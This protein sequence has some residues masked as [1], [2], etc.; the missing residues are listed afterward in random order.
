MDHKP[1][2]EQNDLITR[3]LKLSPFRIAALY[4][5]AGWLWIAFSDAALGML[6]HD[7]D[8]MT[9]IAMVKG[10]AYVAVTAAILYVLILRFE[11]TSLESE[12]GYRALLEQAVDGIVITDQDANCLTVNAS[13]CAMLGYTET[14]FLRLNFRDLILPEDLAVTPLRSNEMLSGRTVL[15]DRMLR[16][17]DG[18]ILLAEISGKML[19]DGRLLAMVRDMSERKRA[20][21]ALEDSERRFRT[22]AQASFEG[23]ALTEQGVIVDVNDQLADMLGYD[24]SE[25]IGKPVMDIVA[26]ESRQ[27]VAEAMRSGR[28]ETYEHLALRKNGSVFPVEVRARSAQIGGRKVRV[29]AVRDV[30]ARKHLEE[31]LLQSQK[32]EAVGLLAGGVAHDFNNIL[33]AII[34]YGSVAKMRLPAGDPIVSYLDNILAS[35]ERAANLT[36]SLLAFS[37][38]QVIR[39]RP[40]YANGI[41]TKVGKLLA[42]LIGEDV[43]LNLELAG[44]DMTILADVGQIEQVLMNLATNGRDAMPSGGIL[45]IT[46]ERIKLDQDFVALS[47]FGVPGEYAMITVADTGMGMDE[48]TRER[49]FEPFFTTKKMGKGTGLGLS[50][51]YGIIKQHEGHITVDSEPGM[52]TLFTIYLPLVPEDAEKAPV[53]APETGRGGSETV[54]V[55]E[56]DEAVRNLI[57]ILLSEG[58]YTVVSA[59]DGEDAVRKFMENRKEVRLLVLD[60]IMPKKNGIEAYEEIRAIKPDIKVLYMSGYTADVFEKKNIPEKS[61]NLITKPVSPTELLNKVRTTLDG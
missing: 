40:V 12:S 4:A 48:R 56:D 25:L 43:E 6:V 59:V 45:T 14:E 19:K 23:I 51:V 39:P 20:E 27:Q 26:S 53:S 9:R 7:P 49:I 2:N 15:I 31:Q 24:R 55:A 46:T 21:G 10:W 13:A 8:V 3:L 32:M 61:L 34:G 41:I 29:S 38:K 22:L 52:G 50:I 44:R 33:T 47:G 58:G 1:G 36:N 18:T 60:V 11:R 28:Q 16:R 54:L 5:V 35:S 37:R 17:R 30:T 42:R 57:V